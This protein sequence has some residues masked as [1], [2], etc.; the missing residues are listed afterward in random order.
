[1]RYLRCA[2][3]VIACGLVMI[4][5]KA[6]ASF[7]TISFER[8]TS[9]SA[10]NVASQLTAALWD[11][12]Q[13]NAEYSLTLAA[14]EVLFTFQNNVGIQSSI[15]EVYFDDG[16]ILAQSSVYNSLGGSTSFTGMGANPSNLPSGENVVPPF[17]ATTGFSADAVGNPSVGVDTAADILGLSYTLQSGLGYLDTVAALADG[18][19]RIGLHLRSIGDAE[20]SDAFVNSPP[21]PPPPPP[22][23]TP[24]PTPGVPEANGLVIWALL[25][26]VGLVYNWKRVKN[27]VV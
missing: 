4:S 1:M 24:G 10:E 3:V 26:L 25:G 11:A 7:T 16:T 13:A 8:I 23:P 5:T 12:T 2:A 19:L 9:N 17:V 15:S 22:P 20:D 18:S 6:S 21:P 14:N 27:F